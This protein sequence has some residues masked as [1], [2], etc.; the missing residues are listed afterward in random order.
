MNNSFH[1][2]GQSSG[3]SG[4]TVRSMVYRIKAILPRPIRKLY[5]DVRAG[6]LSLGL[7]GGREFIQTELERE[8][9]KH[10]SIVI[11]VKDQ[12]SVVER[13]LASVALFAAESEIII[14]D[15]ASVL[16]ETSAILKDF[17]VRRGWVSMRNVQSLGHSRCCEIGAAR[18][19]REYICLLNSDTVVTPR[20]WWGAKDAF[21]CD[22]TIGVVG[23]TT[24]HSAT[25][26]MLRRAM[27][28]RHYWSDNQIFAFAEKY[29][30]SQK[31]RSWVDLPEIGGFA[32]CIRRE[33]WEQLHGFDE[34]LPDYG[35][36]SELCVRVRKL[37]LRVVWTQ[38]SYI[39]H[40]GGQS[41]GGGADGFIRDKARAGN[42]YIA[43][44]YKHECIK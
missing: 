11:A 10:L 16:D 23:P 36:E 1:F 8:A 22:A 34:N 43:E 19:T 31:P 5:R 28:C 20:S 12:P 6:V 2:V 44:K 41:Y 38:N 32:F 9:S 27:H 42:D 17:A 26:Q 25:E 37:G 40:F 29:V 35:N 13:C 24:S 33:L 3:G 7:P 39:H 15:D 21:E 14:V 18:A 30:G 4:L